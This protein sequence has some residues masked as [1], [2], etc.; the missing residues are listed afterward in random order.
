M[1]NQAPADIDAV[2]AEEPDRAWRPSGRPAHRCP[3]TE[4]GRIQE[5]DDAGGVIA[6]IARFV[7][8]PFVKLVLGLG[9][10]ILAAIVYDKT[11]NFGEWTERRAKPKATKHP[12]LAPVQ[13]TPD[14]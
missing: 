8:R 12:G 7:K 4:Q 10:F 3:P 1:A 13:Q 11:V 9:I 2:V 6:K 14:G 5:L